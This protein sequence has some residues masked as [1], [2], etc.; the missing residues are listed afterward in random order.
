MSTLSVE[1]VARYR[2]DGAIIVRGVLGPDRLARL[3]EVID[4]FVERS[5]ELTANDDVFVLEPDHSRA[6]PRLRRIKNAPEQHPVFDELLRS[7]AVL[8]PVA[9][10][11]GPD[12]RYQ[13]GKLNM[14][15]A[16]GGSPVGWH[17]DFAFYP[18]TNDDVL[19]VG[20]VLDDA[21][22][23][24]GCMLVVPGSH[25]GPI[26]DHHDANGDFV[27]AVDASDPLVA[28]AEW[29]PLVCRAGDLT[30]HHGRT[31]HASAPNRSGR[32]RRLLLFELMAGDAFPLL[33]WSYGDLRRHMVRGQLAREAR[34]IELRVLLPRWDRDRLGSIFELQDQAAERAFAA[35]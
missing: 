8:D 9:E 7:D 15:V 2:R 32:S 21:G 28:D 35:T 19:A 26:L 16:G 1:Q 6:R 31:L 12:I 13:S 33:P 30:I 11:I 23:D 20:V 24:N 22:L 14:K 29:R 17:Q 25:T 18:H 4:E 3:H 10:L 27:G 5:R 34:L